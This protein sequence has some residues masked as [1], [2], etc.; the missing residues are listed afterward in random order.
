MESSRFAAW[1]RLL[2]ARTTDRR[3]AGRFAAGIAALALGSLG[4]AQTDA[5]RRKK[6]CKGNKKKCGNQCIPKD[7][8]CS[9]RDCPNDWD[10]VN[11]VCR[12]IAGTCQPSDG[13]C[14]AQ[15]V[16]CGVGLACDCFSTA[17]GVRCGAR[18]TESA[19]G[20]CNDAADCAANG[21]GDDPFCVNGAECCPT[22]RVGYCARACTVCVGKNDCPKGCLCGDRPESE[23]G[24][25]VVKDGQCGTLCAADA[26]CPTTH[27]CVAVPGCAGLTCRR[28]CGA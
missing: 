4:S 26:N 21:Y 15:D 8:C 1:S 7:A 25:C 20:D 22:P 14:P 13:F 24:R 12:V 16:E 28:R 9:D 11:R 18:I 23:T 27:R 6:K 3:A 2:A 19:C 17:R 5:K 10:C